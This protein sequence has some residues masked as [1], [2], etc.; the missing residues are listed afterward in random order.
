VVER[1]DTTG[2]IQISISIPE[3][4]QKRA[5]GEDDTIDNDPPDRF[6]CDPSGI[7]G[8]VCSVPVVSLRSTTG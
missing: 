8:I 3:G 5:A 7:V 6:G 4:S 2:K 1:S